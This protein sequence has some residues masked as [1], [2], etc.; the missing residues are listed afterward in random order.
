MRRRRA[1]LSAIWLWQPKRHLAVH[2]GHA[3]A[4][5]MRPPQTVVIDAIIL[6][7]HARLPYDPHN[8]KYTASKFTQAKAL[9]TPSSMLLQ[10][11]MFWQGLPIQARPGTEAPVLRAEQSAVPGWHNNDQ[12]SPGFSVQ[13]ECIF[14]DIFCF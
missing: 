5:H 4:A 9:P 12:N 2:L 10:A 7:V 14:K 6:L 11:A 8:G 13:V 1:R 3:S